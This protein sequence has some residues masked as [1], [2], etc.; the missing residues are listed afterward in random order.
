M[1]EKYTSLKVILDKLL[2]NSL[3]E[4]LSYEAVIDY[5][6]S[7]MEIVGVPGNFTE[8]LFED[9]IINYR[10]KLPCDYIEDIQ[11]LINNIPARYATDTFHKQYKRIDDNTFN[12]TP[13]DYT[14]IIENGYVFTSVKDGNLKMVYN[15]INTDEE[16]YPMI[17]DNSKFI[18][19]LEW[20]C[21][22]QYYT[23]LWERGKIT[24]KVFYHTESE[25]CWAVGACETDMNKLDLSKAESLFNSFR[26]LLIRDNEFSKRFINNGAKEL[27]KN[28]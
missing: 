23:V 21:K 12:K 8:E 2:R 16:G 27:I 5:T 13:A 4:G 11:L 9:K 28:K 3:L 15:A 25:Y 14:F 22:L 18:R 17:P 1:A 10:V 24:D 26:T 6:I 7:F 20:Y 19:A